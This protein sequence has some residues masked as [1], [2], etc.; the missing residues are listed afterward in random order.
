MS[1]GKATA[2]G[3][4]ERSGT[5]V[6]VAPLEETDLPM[7]RRAIVGSVPRIAPWG[8][9][10]LDQLSELVAAQGWSVRSFL[11]H[12]L[13]PEASVGPEA[14][15]GSA[16][17]I[18]GRVNVN[19]L[20]RGRLQSATIGYDAY[21]PY[22]GRGLMAEGLRLVLDVAFAP[23]P[24]GLGLHR[25]QA[26]VQPANVRSAGLLRA[27]GFV[28]EGFSPRL[29]QLPTLGD[30]TE[31]WRDHDNYAITVEQ[32]PAAPYR[33]AEPR[34]R[35]VLVHGLPGAGKST[36]ASRLAVELGLPLLRK[37]AIK[38]ALADAMSAEPF[39]PGTRGAHQDRSGVLGA[40]ASEAMWRLLAQSPNGG[41]VESWF[42]P[43]DRAHVLAGL[44]GA[45]LDPATVIEVYC[46][47]PLELAMARDAAR[48]AQG[49]RH[50]V[51][52]VVSE[53]EWRG[54]VAAAAKPLALGP[55]CRVDT[56]APVPDA[57]IVR[58]ALAVLAG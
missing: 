9:T 40:A 2:A 47:V 52:R 39:V 48:R 14:G 18:V 43:H 20:V 25:V 34:R 50:P 15:P 19:H 10:G 7:L 35:V 4:W 49:R 24:H 44:A 27:V 33:P 57:E 8:P 30:A 51:H 28:H 32:W 12:A 54:P 22:A 11:V 1:A 41:V 58:I 36:L 5:R 29:V 21:D 6:R 53:A 38:E 16:H 23:E 13:D 37:D 46:D 17:G 3:R 42:W 55:V 26:G 45:G 56:S 31:Q